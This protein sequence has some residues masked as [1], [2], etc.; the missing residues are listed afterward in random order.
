MIGLY[1]QPSTPVAFKCEK[2]SNCLLNHHGDCEGWLEDPGSRARSLVAA[3]GIDENLVSLWNPRSGK[4]L[5][6]ITLEISVNING[7]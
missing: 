5:P 2:A 4:K 3:E 7:F 1:I 6:L